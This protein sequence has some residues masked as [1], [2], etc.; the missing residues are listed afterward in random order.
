M[1]D[2][3]LANETK[4][5]TSIW[6][7]PEYRVFSNEMSEIETVISWA[8]KK[9]IY[10]VLDIGCGEGYGVYQLEKEGYNVYGLDLVYV[11]KVPLKNKPFI[12]PAWVLPD[13][14]Y[15]LIIAID[16]LEH[17]PQD[18]IEYVFNEINK[19]CKFFYFSIA[20]RSDQMGIMIKQDLHLT[21][22]NPSWWLS[23]VTGYFDVESF[24]GGMKNI[25]I[26]GKQ[27]IKTGGIK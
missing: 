19:R 24:N 14:N 13:A 12:S 17:L 4:K 2:K 25:V 5:Y 3:F 1:E 6:K 9:P 7:Y 16:V 10:T 15:D 27:K 23:K 20:C 18:K 26:K 8:K 21:V 22:K 11:I